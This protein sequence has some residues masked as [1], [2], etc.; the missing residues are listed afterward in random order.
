MITKERLEELI[1][2]GA[3]IY[4]IKKDFYIVDPSE[5]VK[6]EKIKSHLLKEFLDSHLEFNEWHGGTDRLYKELFETKEEADFALRYKRIPKIEYL[7]LPTWEEFI[8]KDKTT[9]FYKNQVKYQMY[10]FVKNKNTDNCKIIIY[11][12]DNS[13]DW[14]VFEKPLTKEN[15]IEACKLCLRLFKGE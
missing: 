15:Y 2:Q 14:I 3:T 13:Q 1:E 7:D 5:I 10:I 12:D 11:A 4:E 6:I 8:T 9:T